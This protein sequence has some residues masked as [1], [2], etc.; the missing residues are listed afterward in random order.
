MAALCIFAM[1]AVVVCLAGVLVLH[2]A[3]ALDQAE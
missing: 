3:H 1:A 2:A